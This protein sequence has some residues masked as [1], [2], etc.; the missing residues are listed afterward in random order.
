MSDT[1]LDR[2]KFLQGG[3]ALAGLTAGAVH[4]VVAQ[5]NEAP[6]MEALLKYGERSRFVTSERV[7]DED[8]VHRH[9][10]RMEG[11][12]TPLQDSMGV[13]TP[14]SLHFVTMHGY[15]PPDINPGE[16][17]LMIHGMVERP[18]I[19]S[20]DE[21]KRLPSV[22]RV[23]FLECQAN[24]P[25]T[26]GKTVQ[27]T[28]GKTSCSEWTGVLLSVL[29]QEAGLDPKAEWVVYEGAE[30]GKMIKSLPMAKALAD[31]IVAYGQNGEPIRPQNGYPLRMLVPGF[32]ALY[33]IKWLRRI[34]V[35][36]RPYMGYQEVRQYTYRPGR[37]AD[38]RIPFFNFEMGPKSVIT[39]PSGEQKLIGKGIHQIT[40]LAWSGS[41]AITRVEV[42]TDN[43][44]TWSDAEIQGPV[45]SVAHTRFN[46]SWNWDGQATVIMSRC[47]D[48]LGQVQPSSAQFA[49]YWGISHEGLVSGKER[50]SGHHNSIQPWGIRAD[51]S[52]Y[53]AYA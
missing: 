14:S 5:T 13:I 43:G 8:E 34:K 33:S 2:R 51:G 50:G 21:L 49:A 53:N 10:H 44:I 45:H 18:L 11:R 23:H 39:S 26:L 38:E 46:F 25:E 12:L 35:V 31:T 22:S 17:K 3:T 20:M 24:R 41:G 1:R 29:L 27:L 37:N 32:E 36:D 15:Y 7:P 42:S 6:D 48:E 16:H 40:G 52:V 4:S 47:T 9:Y 19:L 28:A 30:P